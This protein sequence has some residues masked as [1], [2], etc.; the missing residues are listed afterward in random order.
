MPKYINGDELINRL[1]NDLER[2]GNYTAEQNPYKHAMR[3]SVLY[4]ICLVQAL[5]EDIV[6][7]KNCVYA[8]ENGTT[9]HYGVGHSTRP[10]R[11]CS[12]GER[13]ESEVDAE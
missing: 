3:E 8:N 9:C 4:C 1:R 7:C 10:E 5:K 6:C 11:F 13:R 12:E 2:W